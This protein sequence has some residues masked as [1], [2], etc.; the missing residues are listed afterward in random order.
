MSRTTVD[1]VNWGKLRPRVVVE[2]KR[3]VESGSMPASAALREVFVELFGAE[4]TRQDEVRFLM[5]AAPIARKLTIGL[6]N[7][8]DR[9]GE[10]DVSFAD[11]R[12]WLGWLDMFDPLCAR[13]IDLHYFAGMSTKETATALDLPLQTVVR[14]L[15]FAKAWLQ[16]KLH[17]A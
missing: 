12:E 10:S 6:A 4:C 9:V 15:R 14:E 5:F 7:A 3:R 17:P 16:T 13:M 8:N 11:L 2:L 1:A